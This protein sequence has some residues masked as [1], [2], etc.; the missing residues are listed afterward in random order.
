MC[1]AIWSVSTF[2]RYNTYAFLLCAIFSSYTARTAEMFYTTDMY[3]YDNLSFL[4]LVHVGKLISHPS[5]D[6]LLTYN[7]PFRVSHYE[8][9][10]KFE[11][12]GMP[13]VSLVS[14]ISKS[15][16][17]VIPPKLR[18]AVTF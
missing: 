9:F 16:T 8:E 15:R 4:N 5:I 14:V 6:K 17:S 12:Q 10:R 13:Q 11:S 3:F 1:V 18:L 2:T 7:G